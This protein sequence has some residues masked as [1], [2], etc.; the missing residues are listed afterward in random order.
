MAT[1][2]ELGD[3]R[4]IAGDPPAALDIGEH[5]C[6]SCGGDGL[7][8]DFEGELTI[9]FGCHGRCTVD[10]DDTACPVHSALHPQS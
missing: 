4:F 10:C 1:I 8:Y 7:E 2:I 6:E 9:C 5:W 3:G